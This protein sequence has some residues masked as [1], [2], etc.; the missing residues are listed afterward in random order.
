MR[1]R[2]L[3]TLMAGGTALS[4]CGELS[5]AFGDVNSIIVA[6]DPLVWAGIETGLVGQLET[7]VF[8]VREEKMFKITYQNP[9]EETWGRLRLFKQE[10]LIGTED[11]P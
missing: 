4:G 8:T 6:A 9:N 11:Q 3:A 10:L 1:N 5:L 7:T 2:I